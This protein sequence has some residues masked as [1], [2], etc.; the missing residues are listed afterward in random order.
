MKTIESIIKNIA[1]EKFSD[2]SY[3]FDNWLNADR[4]LEGLNYPAIL[5][6]LPVSGQTEIKNG[7]VYDTENIA[8]AFLD[9]APRGADGTDNAE[10]YNRMKVAG[11]SFIKALIDSRCFDGLDGAQYY[12]TICEQLSTIVSGVMYSL[13][14]TQRIGDCMNG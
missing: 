1:K 10:I 5:C 13:R 4:V 2:F 9:L 3:V 8:I 11:A 6:V 12:D 7:K 14:L